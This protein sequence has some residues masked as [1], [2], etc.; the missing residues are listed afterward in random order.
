MSFTKLNKKNF[1]VKKVDHFSHTIQQGLNVLTL[2]LKTAKEEIWKGKTYIKIET[3]NHY[4]EIFQKKGLTQPKKS[5][6]KIAKRMSKVIMEIIEDKFEGKEPDKLHL[7]VNFEY[8][9]KSAMYYAR[10]TGEVG[11]KASAVCIK[12]G[13]FKVLY[14]EFRSPKYVNK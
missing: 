4:C 8:K 9:G 5:Y 11:I 1:K 7:L 3:E 13:H 12:N 14:K 10:V 2:K 6:V